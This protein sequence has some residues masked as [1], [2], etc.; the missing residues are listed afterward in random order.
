MC[1]YIDHCVAEFIDIHVFLPDLNATLLPQHINKQPKNNL[2]Y[3][4]M[5]KSNT[6]NVH[7][8]Q[9]NTLLPSATIMSY[10]HLVYCANSLQ[11]HSHQCTGSDLV[12]QINEDDNSVT[13]T[14]KMDQ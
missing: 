13:T 1:V 10:Y 9:S 3:F 11:Q 5:L 8:I 6:I 4:F 12:K 2:P 14:E 7:V